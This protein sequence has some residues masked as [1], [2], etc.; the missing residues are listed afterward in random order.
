MPQKIFLF[1]VFAIISA[2]IS[3][4]AAY[5]QERSPLLSADQEP[6]VQVDEKFGRVEKKTDTEGEFKAFLQC[7]TRPG[8]KKYWNFGIRF[9]VDRKIEKDE[10]LFVRF[11]ARTTYARTESGIGLV[12]PFFEQDSSPF[13]KSL[14]KRIE[15]GREWKEYGIAFKSRGGYAPGDAD[16]GIFL[17]HQ[18][19]TIEIADFM[20]FSY[21]TE[22]ELASIPETIV[23]YSGQEPDA[24]WRV[25]AEK[26]IE[27]IR[28]GDLEIT[29][30]D[31]NGKPL[32]D[33]EIEIRMK[34]HAFRWGTAVV[35]RRFVQDDEDSKKYREIIERNFN[36]V[37]FENDMKWF[38]WD[39]LRNR[40]N[41]F[42]ALEWLEERDI[43]VRGHCLVWPSW[44][45]TPRGL[46]ELENDPE[47]LREAVRKHVR[48][49]AGELDGKLL[50]WDVVNEPYDNNDLL[51][52]LGREEMAEWFKITREVDPEVRLFLN[53]YGILS[54]EGRDR[55]KLD[56]MEN[57]IRFLKENDAPIGGIGFQSHFSSVPTPPERII[58]ILDRFAKFEFPIAITE[59]DIDSKDEKIQHEFTRDFLTAV[60]SHPAVDSVLVWGF[61]EKS[62]W[63]PDAAYY[64]SDWSLRPHGQV[65]NDLV[66]KK[67]LTEL[68]EKTDAEGKV[69]ARCFLGDY[70]IT[71]R[72]DGRTKSLKTSLGKDG[73]KLEIELD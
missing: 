10:V 11:F 64:R 59:H 13:E 51:K 2:L 58:E 45:N 19:Q 38:A 33:A 31:K 62:H 18:E 32:P 16:V 8:E 21:G 49:E 15:I 20:L 30:L 53:D 9:K 6:K 1:S 43:A 52:I 26:R 36:C 63:R 68:D 73:A 71:V 69:K 40:E 24:A 17:G 67:W 55:R 12:S 54:S 35:A 34:R 42:K 27:E 39:N 60:F 3:F 28:K 4:S 61:W 48:D 57:T 29:V 72:K 56:F 7:E 50:D 23:R 46:R 41:V 37:V 70:E 5:S 25:A 65:W 14:D 66:M 47:K 22:T 44:R